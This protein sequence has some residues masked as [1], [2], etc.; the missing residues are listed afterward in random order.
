[1]LRIAVDARPLAH[2]QTGI[3][4]YTESLL[5]RLVKMGHQWFLYSDRAITPR[6]TVDDHVQIRMG[7]AR[8]GS[9]LSLVYSQLVFP[10]WARGDCVDLF[11][12]PRHHLPLRLPFSVKGVVSVHDLVWKRYPETMHKLN[13]QLEQLLMGPSLHQAAGII[14]VS[15]FTRSEIALEY[16]DCEARCVTIPE[17]AEV[18]ATAYEEQFPLPEEPY[19]LFVG[20]P[21]PRKNLPRLLQAFAS[22][23][24]QG[25]Q[26]S[27][28][29][30]GGGGWGDFDLE[31]AIQELG[32]VGLVQC[33]GRVSDAELAA[34]YDN[35]TALLIPSL[36]EGFG[37]PA[38]EAMSHGTPVI[39]SNCSALP[40]VVRDGGLLVDP[41]S[42][43][44]IAAAI[45]R[46]CG[47]ASLQKRLAESARWQASGYNWDRS[48]ELTMA[49]LERIHHDRSL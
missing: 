37:L 25:V 19:L 27:L 29:L 3:G 30:V 6:F 9:A 14:A 45:I 28:V 31:D 4:R 49:A 34:L 41:E 1:V 16:P 44:S 35:A 24:Q 7:K 17:A 38:L 18:A 48:A 11:W 26:H 22:A 42:V 2:P 36:Y 47:D 33:R 15:E 21:E 46:L 12:S 40:E 5:Q 10:R 43:G 32:L 23:R 8:P 39:A 13:K 20:T